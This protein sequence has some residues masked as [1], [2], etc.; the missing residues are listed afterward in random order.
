MITLVLSEYLV[1]T[2]GLKTYI[3]IGVLNK[4]IPKEPCTEP[5]MLLVHTDALITWIPLL[6][7]GRM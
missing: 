3:M 4:I 2:V 1:N 6:L 7:P 5:G